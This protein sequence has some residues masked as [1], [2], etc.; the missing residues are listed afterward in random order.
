MA[1]T[2]RPVLIALAP[3][4]TSNRARPLCGER[5]KFLASLIGIEPRTF[6]SIFERRYLFVRAPGS[7]GAEATKLAREATPSLYGRDVIFV[8]L[9]VAQA[10]GF[11]HLSFRFFKIGLGKEMYWAACSPEPSNSKLW[12][13]EPFLERAQEFWREEAFFIL[14]P[15][16]FS[17]DGDDAMPMPD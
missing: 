13:E 5:G 1:D 12:S 17:G 8:G 11:D 16:D 10:F 14:H 6:A 9:G 2:Q 3:R 7:V 4:A 15:D